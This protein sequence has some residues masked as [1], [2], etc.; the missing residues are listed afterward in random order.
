MNAQFSVETEQLAFPI[1]PKMGETDSFII[2]PDHDR[3]ILEKMRKNKTR[4]ELWD[5][6]P[7]E[8]EY[9]K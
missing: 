8:L 2:Y 9:N 4:T 3:K 5:D 1:R 7:T 6:L